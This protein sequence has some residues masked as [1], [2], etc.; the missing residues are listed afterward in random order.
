MSAPRWPSRRCAPCGL[1]A[2]IRPRIGGGIRP[3]VWEA[4]GR[5][6]SPARPRRQALAPAAGLVRREPAAALP[7]GLP[8]PESRTAGGGV[9]SRRTPVPG[10]LIAAPDRRAPARRRGWP[11]VTLAQEQVDHPAPADVLPAAPAVPQHVRVLAPGVLERV[12]QHRYRAEVP[13][14]V[15]APRQGDGGG[16]APT[17]VEGDRAERV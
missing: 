12:G 14:V 3:P 5:R 8:A 6:G 9:A 16:A 1:L 10:S 11:A 17:R 15:H 4:A 13:L 7:V 2:A